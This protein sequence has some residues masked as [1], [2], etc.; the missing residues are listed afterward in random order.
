M[1]EESELVGVHDGG[2]DLDGSGPV[3]VEVAEG[4]GEV[5]HRALGDPAVVGGDVVVGGEGAAD[6]DLLGD[7][8]EVVFLALVLLV[9]VGLGV[10]G[11]DD[12][13]LDERARRWVEVVPPELSERPLHAGR[14]AG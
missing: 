10:G 8:E 1:D 12:G 4:V 3:E 2:R 6:V 5:D 13:V 14:S 7:H 9:D 11:L